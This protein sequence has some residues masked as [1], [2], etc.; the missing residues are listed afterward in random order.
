MTKEKRK[1]YLLIFI[2]VVIFGLEPGLIKLLLNSDAI[3]PNA[4]CLFRAIFVALVSE[5][6][7]IWSRL[8]EKRKLKQNKEIKRSLITDYKVE[9]IGKKRYILLALGMAIFY[10]LNILSFSSG[11][12]L[13][14]ATLGEFVNSIGATLCVMIVFAIFVKGEAK[15]LKSLWVI[16]SF[17]LGVFGVFYASGNTFGDL[18]NFKMDLGIV[19]ILVSGIT[20]GLYLLFM[21]KLSSDVSKFRIMRD[22]Q[23]V[24]VIFFVIILLVSGDLVST[25]QIGLTNILKVFLF[26]LIVDI[27]TILTYYEALR[28]VSGIIATLFTM[29]CPIITYA[30]CYLV[31]NERISGIQIVGCAILFVSSILLS[32]DQIKDELKEEKKLTDK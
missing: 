5:G 8:N 15:H 2:T 29:A 11:L 23:V 31:L 13:T 24:T 1:G 27:G 10:A 4:M 14:K 3:S 6:V 21:N 30:F 16:I 12:N 32:V 22:T 19:L 7:M 18:A 25:F 9:G 28:I 20:W 26:S 17:I